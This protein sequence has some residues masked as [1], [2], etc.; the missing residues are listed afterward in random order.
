[1]RQKLFGLQGVTYKVAH[2]AYDDIDASRIPTNTFQKIASGSTGC[3]STNMYKVTIDFTSYGI[4]PAI[5]TL[6]ALR[7]RPVYSDATIAVD[8]GTATLPKQGNQIISTGTT[9]ELTRKII[10]NQQYR[11][12]SSAFDGGVFSQES[13]GH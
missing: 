10:V 12:L 8:T 5:D 6:L 2:G 11:S 3:N 7:I 9:S 13:F 1:V 4:N